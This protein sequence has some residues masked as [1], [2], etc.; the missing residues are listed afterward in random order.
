M[1][2]SDTGPEQYSNLE[3]LP[4]LNIRCSPVMDW[5]SR[6]ARD[7][8]MGSSLPVTLQR[9]SGFG[10]WMDGIFVTFISG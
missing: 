8:G 9:T 5:P 10:E 6:V 4:F 7:A 3:C 2:L 1:K